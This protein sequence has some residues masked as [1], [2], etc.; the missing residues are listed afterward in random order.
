MPEPAGASAPSPRFPL[1]QAMP[2]TPKTASP[3]VA[4]VILRV[5]VP[6]PLRRLFDYLPPADLSDASAAGL[7]PGMRVAVP[8]GTRTLVAILVS[9]QTRSSVASGKLKRA[10]H[11]IDEQALLPPSLMELYVWAAQ[12]YQHPPGEVFQTM[13]PALL[14]QDR[15]AA[16]PPRKVWRLTDAGHALAPDA[17]R[18]A[19]RQR[20]IIDFLSEH[21]E[22][23]KTSLL[24]TEISPAAL[25]TLVSAGLVLSLEE[26]DGGPPPALLHARLGN[27]V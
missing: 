5:A 23:D 15:P 27:Q 2:H 24:E 1:Q 3:V 12:Y 19:P 16:R 6:S 18:R 25:A 8:F 11:L 9:V 13:L 14:R 7:V 26:A 17:L 22:L 20:E 21:G 4:P 10:L